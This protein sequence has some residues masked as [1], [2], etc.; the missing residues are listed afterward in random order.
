MNANVQSIGRGMSKP[1]TADTP[2]PSDAALLETKN[3]LTDTT[4]A[5]SVQP[6]FG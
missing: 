5:A 1:I 4:Q 6:L 2:C 3:L